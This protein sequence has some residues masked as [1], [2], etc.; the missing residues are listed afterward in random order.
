MMTD[1]APHLAAFL[2]KHLPC[3]QRASRHT[4]ASYAL[5]FQLL[6]DFA[7]KSLGIRPCRMAVEHLTVPLI[8]DF[9]DSLEQE[10]NNTA[11]TRNL[12]LVAIKS[13]FRYLEYRVPACLDRARQVHAIPHKRFKRALLDYLDREEIQ[14]LLD[15]PDTATSGG[16]RDRA[17]LH[18]TFAAGLRVSELIGLKR[19]DLGVRLETVRVMGKGRRARVLPLWK[20][21]QSVLGSWLAIRPDVAYDR[22]FLNARG[23]PMSRHGFAHR[24]A[25]HATAARQTKASLAGKRIS[26]HVL[27]HSCAMHTLKATGDIRKV[28]LWLGHASLQSTEMYLHA[29]P[30]EKLDVLQSRVPPQLRKGTFENVPD[31][32]M[33]M[34]ADVKSC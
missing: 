17:M 32:L 23:R 14:T 21:T 25:L 31:S 19:K 8:L 9:L 22:L 24:L 28:S 26:P 12:R 16:V 15:A 30:L 29:D 13:F 18:L 20:E 27:R 11:R 6:L 3:E 4:V 34:L 10:R 7:A 33:A 5:S 1:L 2:R